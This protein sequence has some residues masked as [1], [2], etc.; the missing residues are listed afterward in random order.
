MHEITERV[1]ALATQLDAQAVPSDELGRLTDE[2]A[3]LLRSTGIVRMLQAKDR[4]GYE[5]H[6]A[7]FLEAVMATAAIA[8][9]AGWVAGVVGVHP[10]ELSMADPALQEELW[11]SDEDTWVASP[12]A[13]M[14][15]AIPTDDGFRL[16]GRWSFSSGTDLCD[17]VVI[18]GLVTNPDGDPIGM[19]HFVLPRSD[20]QIVEDSWQVVGLQGTG[21][22]DLTVDDAFVPGYRTID[23]PALL[24]GSLAASSRPGN[25]LYAL[26][27]GVLFSYAIS[28]ATVGMCEGALAAFIAFTEGRVTLD[29]SRA[30]QHTHQLTAMGAATADINASRTV[31]LSNAHRMFD[32]TSAGGQLSPSD[33]IAFRNDQVRAARRA[34]DAVDILFRY[35]G[36]GALRLDSPIQRYWRDS[37]AAMNHLCNVADPIQQSYS[38]DRFGGPITALFY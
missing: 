31:L 1:E 18:G 26:P 23:V 4:G 24:N 32:I 28:S 21:S 13:P 30:A 33:R 15:R 20:Y 35:A 22:K 19:R 3:D 2:T 11:G 7:E 10:W 16:T 5:V 34:V 38:S 17:W 36:G 8:P 29:G 27:F 25:P 12:Y 6:P 14:G 9:S 37:H